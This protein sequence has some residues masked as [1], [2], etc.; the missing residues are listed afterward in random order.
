MWIKI[1]KYAVVI[2]QATGLDK[3]VKDWVHGKLN[4]AENKLD[5]AAAKGQ[6]KINEVRD[7]LED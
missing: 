6:A 1:L 4:K 2:A 5:E 7:L 3:K